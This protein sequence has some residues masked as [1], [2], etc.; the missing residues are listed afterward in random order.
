M[1]IEETEVSQV[2]L[3]GQELQDDEVLEADQSAYEMLHSMSVKWPCLSFDIL[4]DSL[5]EDRKMVCKI[6]C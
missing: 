6:V 1:E 5:G 3:P 2:Y 4:W